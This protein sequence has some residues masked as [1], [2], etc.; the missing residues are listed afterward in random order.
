M[1]D[2]ERYRS[3][4]TQTPMIDRGEDYCALE[5]FLDRFERNQAVIGAAF[6]TIEPPITAAK[7]KEKIMQLVRAGAFEDM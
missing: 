5:Y 3:A 6:A 2:V 1:G 7:M 4:A